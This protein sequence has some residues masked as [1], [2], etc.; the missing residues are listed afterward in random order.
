MNWTTAEKLSLNQTSATIYALKPVSTYVFRA[1]LVGYSRSGNWT[2]L[3]EIKTAEGIPSAIRN[4]RLTELSPFGAVVSW[5]SPLESNGAISYFKMEVNGRRSYNASFYQSINTN[6][7]DR[8][9]EVLSRLLPATLYNISIYARNRKYIGP[10]SSITYQ[11]EALPPLQPDPV[12]LDEATSIFS[13]VKVTAAAV[14]AVYGPV[15]AYQVVV[16]LQEGNSKVLNFSKAVPKYEEARLR[17]LSFYETRRLKPFVGASDFYIGDGRVDSGLTNAPLNQRQNYTIYIRAVTD[18]NSNTLYSLPSATH[19][20]RYPLNTEPVLA[21]DER[22]ASSITIKLVKM[23]GN[24]Q[25]MRIIVQRIDLQ[26]AAELPQ[27]DFYYESNITLYAA[28]K[29]RQFMVPYV[30]AELG[31]NYFEAVDRFVIGDGKLTNRSSTRKRR[32]ISEQNITS[33]FNGP[34]DPGSS[35]VVFFRA[36]HKGGVYFS[37]T[38]SDPITTEQLTPAAKVQVSTSVGLIMGITICAIAV[39]FFIIFGYVLWKRNRKAFDSNYQLST[40]ELVGNGKKSRMISFFDDHFDA[41]D[42]IGSSTATPPYD[43]KYEVDAAHQPI[44]ISDFSGYYDAMKE[45]DYA[46][47][48]EFIELRE[49]SSKER[50]ASTGNIALNKDKEAVALD[51]ARVVLEREKKGASNYINAA[52]V[53]SYNAQNAYIATQSPMKGMI[54]DFWD[55]ILQQNVRTIVMLTHVLDEDRLASPDYWPTS[56]KLIFG[57]GDVVVE[58]KDNVFDDCAVVRGF[59]LSGK[60][61]QPRTVRH[62]QF[63]KWPK[64][65]IPISTKDLLMFRDLV[66]QWHKGKSS[67]QVVHCR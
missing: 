44:L 37:S 43:L 14:P 10:A 51:S 2:P 32:S 9:H 12:V 24:V 22:T 54:K 30:A 42:S 41:E 59:L 53:D 34:L 27:P 45:K 6:V 62:F 18:W 19:L 29:E 7:T 23:H 50:L 28:S 63:N 17:N 5:V 33:F 52:F 49:S 3:V 26:R 20:W 11:T 58:S 60:K 21:E 55:M 16:E 40:M 1:K 36:Y 15:T 48:D 67:P 65:G 64:R 25:Y 57:D 38:W 13:S 31:K 66:N 47:E 46:F 8:T 39:P 4:I 35:Y 61:K 56:V